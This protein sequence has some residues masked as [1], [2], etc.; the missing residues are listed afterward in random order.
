[1]AGRTRRDLTADEIVERA[2]ELGREA[3]ERAVT[4]TAVAAACGVTPM[5]LYHHVADKEELLTLVVDRVVRD[6]VHG[7][8]VHNDASWQDQVEDLGLRFRGAFL[9]HRTAAQ[10]MLRRPVVSVNVARYTELLLSTLSL[11]PLDSR[12][13][14]EAAD[15]VVLLLFGTIANDLTRPPEVRRSLPAQLPDGERSSLDAH[16]ETYAERDPEQRFRTALRW[17]LA[18]VPTTYRAG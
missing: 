12:T 15:A 16:I 3:D 1:M 11:A 17:T 4:M 13:V 14:A 6:A 7:F 9:H 5:A 8:A 2:V 18:G 10:V